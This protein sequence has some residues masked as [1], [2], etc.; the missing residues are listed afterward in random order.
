MNMA[1]LKAKEL[2]QYWFQISAQDQHFQERGKPI[3]L[4]LVLNCVFILAK[5]MKGKVAIGKI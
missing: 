5:G 4:I 2:N 3:T 1:G